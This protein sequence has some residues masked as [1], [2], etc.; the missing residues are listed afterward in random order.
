MPAPPSSPPRKPLVIAL[1][2]AATVSLGMASLGQ[3]PGGA[4]A[5]AAANELVPDVFAA[6]TCRTCHNQD[7]SKSYS[8]E[9]RA[10]M[11]CRMTEYPY[12]EKHDKHRLAFQALLDPR[13][14]RMAERL[15]AKSAT[16]ID[17]CVRCHATLPIGIDRIDQ[18]GEEGLAQVKADGVTCMACHG[19]YQNWVNAHFT[20]FLTQSGLQSLQA[21]TKEKAKEKPKAPQNV[22][23]TLDRKAKERDYGMTDLWDPVRRAEMCVSC[24]VGSAAEG[25]ILTHAMYAAGHPPLP[26]F[27]ASTFSDAQPR[28]WQYLREKSPEQLKRV[29]AIDSTNLEQSQLVAVSGL[30]TLREVMELFADEAE[31]LEGAG[32][33]GSDWPDFARYDCSSCHHDLKPGSW[34][35]ARGYAGSPGRPPAPE[36]PVALVWLGIEAGDPET[37]ES[38]S[39]ELD[40]LLEAF[41]R[42][43]TARPF[44][45][46]KAAIEAARAVAAWADSQAQAI[47]ESPVDRERAAALLK[48]LCSLP[49]RAP[50]YDSARQIAW[51]F[52]TIYHELTP[53]NGRDEAVEDV[54]AQLDRL[55]ALDLPTQKVQTPIEDSLRARLKI[56]ADY[57]PQLVQILFRKLAQTIP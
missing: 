50:D 24:H 18:L 11:I 35:Q 43:V 15:G 39:R 19:E 8:P 42:T 44:G 9:Q 56:A 7:E 45:D 17:A 10:R 53:E 34:R 51:A 28:H 46:R 37:A 14:Q 4:A 26:G 49:T 5:P 55:L 1:A 47:R 33:I 12:F 25:K 41:H 32:P 52:R 48:R 23:L 38:R 13:G 54:L 20:P 36:W 30:I 3:A 21:K 29:G 27:E 16:E 2:C 40:E 22:W 6:E 31:R 57:D